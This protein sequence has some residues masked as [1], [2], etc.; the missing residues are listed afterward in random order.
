VAEA[1]VALKGRLALAMEDNV[2]RAQWLAQWSSFLGADQAVPD[3]AVAIDAVT[4]AELARVVKTYFTP[5]RRYVGLHQPVATVASGAR[6]LAA[7]VG[8]ALTLWGGRR[9][10]RQVQ[11]RR[12]RQAFS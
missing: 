12:K 3:Y 11:A 1:Q 7:A 4:P 9:V 8:L 6:A 10:W 5:E 2:A